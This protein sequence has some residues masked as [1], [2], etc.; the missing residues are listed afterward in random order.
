MDF[1]AKNG[2]STPQVREKLLDVAER[3]FTEQGFSHT[4]VRDLTKN[5]GC[6]IAAVNYHFGGKD[7]L[8]KA[9]FHRHMDR[10]FAKQIA[11]INKVM[12][13]ESPTLENFLE[14]T[15]RTSLEA[16]DSSDGRI[17]VLKLIVR[18]NLNPHMKEKVVKLESFS[19]FL[20]QVCE[21]LVKLVPGLSNDRAFLCFC[22]LQGMVLQPL[23]FH[24]FYA[25]IGK[26]VS[27][28]I[29]INHMVDFAAAGIR[30]VAKSK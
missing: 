26:N 24:D 23:L 9:M 15:F 19:N 10:V 12:T 3:L 20:E 7:Q 28:D 6:N 8:Y 14:T 11:N 21:A 4:S 30:A 25:E 1:Q 17:P 16:L 5:A 29:I 18:E 27:V 2:L 22:S 13:S